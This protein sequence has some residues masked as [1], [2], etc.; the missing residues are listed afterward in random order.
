MKVFQRT[1]AV[2]CATLV[3]AATVFALSFNQDIVAIFGSGNPNTGWTTDSG[4]EQMV[5]ALRAKNRMT[6]A[7]TNVSGVYSFPTGFQAPNINRAVWNWEFSIDSG[8]GNLYA[9]DYYVLIDT[10]YSQ[11]TAYTTVNALVGWNDNSYGTSATL[12]GAGVEG[13]AATYAGSST[14]AQQSQN[15]V[16]AGGNPLLDATYNYQLFAVAPGAGP[17]GTRLATTAITVIVGTGGPAF[18]DNDNDNVPNGDDLCPATAPGDAVDVNGCS[19][20]ELVNKCAIE[21]SS[22]HGEYVSCVVEFANR[23]FKAGTVSQS[24]RKYLINTAARSMI[25]K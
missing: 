17:N 15:L 9:Y 4:P 19:I 11:A 14:I 6:A 7:T 23:F 22:D 25:G 10:D 5:L 21:N 1:V 3:T 8:G 12:N 20:Q 24:E 18:L 2:L 16:F 13:P